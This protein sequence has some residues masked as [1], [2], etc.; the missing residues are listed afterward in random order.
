MRFLALRLLRHRRRTVQFS[1][2]IVLL[3]G[4]RAAQGADPAALSATA[5]QQIEALQSA[6][7]GF[8]TAEQKIDSQLVFALRQG[9]SQA[10]ASGVPL[11]QPDLAYEAD[12]R[13][14][15]DLDAKVSG[16]LLPSI[17]LNGG[18]VYRRQ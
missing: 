15:V 12:G 1:L 4:G 8:S 11:L 7:S 16:E 5:L 9:R 17:N 6:K 14:L 13:V 2:T 10:I 3:L 18:Q